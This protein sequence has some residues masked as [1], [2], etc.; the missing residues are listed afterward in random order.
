[1]VYNEKFI[2][3]PLQYFFQNIY[4][5]FLLKQ[6]YEKHFDKM[7]LSHPVYNK[8]WRVSFLNKHRYMNWILYTFFK[9]AKIKNEDILFRHDIF[10]KN[11]S[12]Y[13]I[14]CYDSCFVSVLRSSGIEAY[15]YD[16]NDWTEMFAMLGT[17]KFINTDPPNPDVCVMLN[18]AH[19]FTP[20]ELFS[21]ISE[22]CGKIP[23]IM[24]FD[25]DHKTYHLHQHL[26]YDEHNIEKYNFQI[27]NFPNY[28]ERDLFIW[29]KK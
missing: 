3:Q 14:G 2:N 17:N 29:Q 13:D 19:N 15:G 27:V 12:V 23:E 26:Y 7:S 24:F 28:Q 8:N 9:N 25:F 16:D 5:N 18:Y 22:K 21:F 11:F 4:D 1:M 20:Q 6:E 10:D